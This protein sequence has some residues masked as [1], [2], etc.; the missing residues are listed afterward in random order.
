MQFDYLIVLVLSGA[1]IVFALTRGFGDRQVEPGARGECQQL[2]RQVLFATGMVLLI[3]WALVLRDCL[4]N[5][6]PAQSLGIGAFGLL[7]G[8]VFIVIL[9]LGWAYVRK[10]E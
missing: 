3:P 1:G 10:C 4:H 9:F 7:M 6:G 2:P 8:G 5:S